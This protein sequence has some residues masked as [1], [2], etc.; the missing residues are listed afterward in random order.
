MAV[1]DIRLLRARLFETNTPMLLLKQ[2][3]Q[4]ENGRNITDVIDPHEPKPL[5]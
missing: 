2:Q 1:Q 4:D 3:Q 5:S